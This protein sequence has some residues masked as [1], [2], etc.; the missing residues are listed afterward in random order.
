MIKLNENIDSGSK[1]VIFDPPH[2]P[3]ESG[4][5]YYQEECIQ[6][7]EDV[8]EGSHLIVLP[9]GS[10]KCFAPGTEI[11]MFDGSVKKIETI[12]E[13]ER[14]MGPDSKPRTVVGLAHGREMMY[15]V[16][17]NRGNPYV[18]NE[19]H[20]LALRATGNKCFTVDNKGTRYKTGDLCNISVKDYL[21]TSKTFKHCMKGYWSDR[22]EFSHKN[23][24]ID[25]YLLGLW[26]GDGHSNE[27]SFTIAN[28]DVEI[29]NFIKEYCNKNKLPFSVSDSHKEK[30]TRCKTYRILAPTRKHF[31]NGLKENLKKYDLLN[32]K[33]IPDAYKCND[34]DI[35]LRLLAGILDTDG[36]Y[37][38][39][40]RT[41]EYTSVS[42]TLF[43]DVLF[44]VRSLGFTAFKKKKIVKG[45]VYYRCSINGRHLNDIPCLLK[46][47][48]AL[49]SRGRKNGHNVGIQVKPV[50]VG[51]YYGFELI[52]PDRLFLLAD[53]TVVHNTFVFS[54]IPRHGRVLI[55]SH[56]DE[57]VHQPQ[58]YYDCSFGVEQAKEHSNGEEVVSASVQS[59]IR[60]L[61]KFDPYDFDMIITDEC[62]HATAPSYQK[63]YE[64]F[65]PR[66]HI[67]FTATPDR[68]D[69]NDLHKIFDDILYIKNMAWGIKEGFL[70][71]I[72]CFQV[73]VKYNLN[74]VKSAMGDWV[75]GALGDAMC[76]EEC[77]TAVAEA[78]RDYHKGQTVI[79][80][81][82]VA[83]ANKVADE[84]NELCSPD[85]R[86]IAKVLTGSTPPE[87]RAK[88]LKD[89]A[90]GKFNCLVNVMVLTEGTDIPCIE[91]V[92]MARPTQNQSLYTQA[93]GRGLRPFPG[94]D[95]LTF[96]DC[97][98]VSKKKPVNVG[99]LFGLNFE[100]V[101]K[102]KRKRLQGV[103]ITEMGEKMEVLMDGP[104]SWI[105][106]VRRVKLFQEDTN[107][108]L[109]DINFTPMGDDSLL[110]SLSSAKIKIMPPDARGESS[111]ILNPVNDTTK[112]IVKN[113]PL[114]EV[115][116]YVYEYLLANLA[117][118]RPLW[119]DR[120]VSKWGDAPASEKQIVYISKLADIKGVSL[121]DIKDE[122]LTK[123]QATALIDRMKVMPTTNPS[124]MR[125][126]PIKKKS[127]NKPR[128]NYNVFE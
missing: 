99:H 6:K 122:S 13:G 12:K 79:F 29:I 11:L 56:R 108:D 4:L 19:S 75:L 16:I 23:I 54:H 45:K 43:D 105:D 95:A 41:Y 111:A 94:K 86:E 73:D 47:K 121:K 67:G 65:K 103:R 68:H 72:D 18:V 100:A 52:G 71:D 40:K 27:T 104:D 126:T 32:N 33:H 9:T 74:Q 42:E 30:Q 1:T 51:E 3:D 92:I 83:H 84:I 93:I 81:A 60:R 70:T 113:R 106:T 46:R 107:A 55:L 14:V 112:M 82:N 66:I 37:D 80:T 26:L 50:G 125:Y 109:R 115:I 96:V 39:K 91:T 61:D 53:F 15:K 98:G 89:F 116:D 8:G 97:V 59:L 90:D 78:Y 7:I 28:Y 20:I 118:E 17:P 22:I 25:P 110:L 21:Q 119:D 76:K 2:V 77:V 62:H 88:M 85:G 120:L 38:R 24:E 63:I 64:Y 69:R 10:G 58:K 124:A 127:V 123:R 44:L 87:D 31:A 34:V 5:R 36:Y 102:K 114:Q 101:P 57:L 49:N 35:R 117:D 48:K 128:K